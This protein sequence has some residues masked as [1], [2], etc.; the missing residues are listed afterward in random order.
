MKRNTKIVAVDWSLVD[1]QWK[2]LGNRQIAE[3]LGTTYPVVYARRKELIRQGIS[4]GLPA[5]SFRPL[6]TVRKPWDFGPAEAL[7]PIM[8]NRQ[9]A[10]E[11]GVPYNA[12]HLKRKELIQDAIL[13]RQPT[14]HYQLQVA[15]PRGTDLSPA[16]GLW[17]T[18]SNIGLAKLL[19]LAPGRVFHLRRGLIARAKQEGQSPAPYIYNPQG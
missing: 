18:T 19:G 1:G 2:S 12:V 17:S 5:E 8:N 6:P 14:A 9:I 15:T 7:W 3:K 4:A 13:K 11:L 16:N 10:Q